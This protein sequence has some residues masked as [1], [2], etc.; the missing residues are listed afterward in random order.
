MKEPYKCIDSYAFNES[1][2]FFGR[3]N[4]VKRMV[5]EIKS[6][7]L[8]VFFSPSGSGKTSLINAGVRPA[9][10]NLGYKT[11]YA[12]C[13]DN[14][15]ASI[16][17]SVSKELK[18]AQ[19]I[20]TENLHDFLTYA[21]NPHLKKDSNQIKPPAPI[22]IF[23]DQF[24]EFFIVLRN[25]PK[26]R[27]AFFKQL[28]S[29][30]NDDQLQVSVV[31]STRD[32]CYVNLFEF[33]NEIAFE[34]QNSDVLLGS[35]SI[36]NARRV[37]EEPA[38]K[39][40]VHY[41]DKLISSVVNELKNNHNRIDIIPLQL[42]CHALWSIKRKNENI[43]HFKDYKFAGGTKN[44][45]QHRIFTIIETIPK[46][47]HK[48]LLKIFLK[49]RTK[50]GRRRF[51]SRRQLFMDLR[52]S[53]KNHAGT[54]HLLNKLVRLN[55]LNREKHIHSV[56]YEIKHD[57]LVNEIK[58]WTIKYQKHINRRLRLRG[59][60]VSFAILCCLFF[61]WFF[62]LFNQFEARFTDQI[63]ENQM[64]EIEILRRFNPFNFKV[65][66]G[67][68]EK[69]LKNTD[70][71]NL[72]KNRY[73]ISSGNKY[74]WHKL[75]EILSLYESGYLMFKAGLIKEGI[76]RLIMGLNDNDIF[77]RVQIEETLRKISRTDRKLIGNLIS[78]LK[79]EDKDFC[80]KFS[81]TV[82]QAEKIISEKIASEDAPKRADKNKLVTNKK[83][84]PSDQSRINSMINT[85]RKA[86]HNDSYV[87][88]KT[89]DALANQGKRD[90]NVAAALVSVLKE[91]DSLFMS[92]VVEALIKLCKNN[93]NTAGTLNS[94]LNNENANVRI[95][96]TDA[97]V[98]IG[99]RDM[100]IIKTL[101]TALKDKDSFVRKRATETL[102]KLGQS[103]ML[104]V[105]ALIRDL[106]D[107]D[108]NVRLNAT[109]ELGEICQRN[110]E[111][112]E[113]LFAL[114]EGGDRDFNVQRKVAD[115]LVKLSKCNQDTINALITTLHD[116]EFTVRGGAADALGEIGNSDQK[117]ITALI[118]AL[119]DSRDDVCAKAMHSLAQLGKSDEKVIAALITALKDGN[120]SGAGKAAEALG[121]INRSDNNI[122]RELIAALED[123]RFSV[124]AG[125]AK[126]LGQLGET[127]QAVIA[128]LVAATNDKS[129]NVKALASEALG[130]L[131][132]DDQEVITALITATKDKGYGVR[133]RALEALGKLDKSDEEIIEVLIA[134]INDK[135]FS[136]RNIAG[137]VL[138]KL[139]QSTTRDEL[140]MMLSHNLSGYRRAAVKVIKLRDS[141]SIDL[142]NSVKKLKDETKSP[143]VHIAAWDAYE[144]IQERRRAD[145]K[146]IY[147]PKSLH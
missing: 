56:W 57:Y 100:T 62:A 142:E 98:A 103:D 47:H 53:K 108:D 13:D 71:L 132:C 88:A 27:K 114:I 60:T 82:T 80:E 38:K 118:T 11:I 61:A 74:N 134:A 5:S 96:V 112:V 36:D 19:N 55:I 138:G 3:E 110:S 20:E 25:H 26:Q 45:L 8:L 130:M 89:I 129:Y 117:V 48:L 52:V 119:G 73:I 65:T 101:I 72:I 32:N 76:K 37:I 40:G 14:P 34:F 83:T 141:I 67:I 91:R 107:R 84:V 140:L 58:E 124:R 39:C 24:E 116:K 4:E 125:A 2:L 78:S 144:I 63:N 69:D 97:Q 68:F 15:S 136:I 23:L 143:W 51:I 35:L 113:S 86:S 139:L 28:L 99:Q 133:I 33:R 90:E 131:R 18:L 64:R 42:V 10:E 120:F 145:N 79:V 17:N 54:I 147:I 70:S 137:N 29:I 127:D 123:S 146:D 128:A 75:F 104:V 115:V 87:R 41:E 46:E 49:L 94:A 95:G 135:D 7:K 50:D 1:G 106:V 109:L 44:I 12:L 31:I 126:A 9:L 66:T 59:T 16:I 77:V 111:L 81:D 85:L 93:K 22:V 30:K 121:E 6:T 105:T 92:G 21:V 102:V 122:I 43:I